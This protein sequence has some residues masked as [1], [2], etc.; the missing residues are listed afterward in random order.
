MKRGVSMRREIPFPLVS[1][2]SYGL[3]NASNEPGSKLSGEN[4]SRQSQGL[5]NE[6]RDRLS[7]I[8]IL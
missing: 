3:G 2:R 1:I 8:F 6:S 4:L 5:G 7:E